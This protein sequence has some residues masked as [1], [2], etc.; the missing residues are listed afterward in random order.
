MRARFI[1]RARLISAALVLVVLC[2]L[3]RLW[4]VQVMDHEY[5]SALADRQYA[6][7]VTGLFERGSIYF[8]DRE[9]HSLAAATLRTGFALAIDPRLIK[10]PETVYAALSAIVPLEK[11]SFLE[12][13]AKKG[14]PHEDLLHRVSEEEAEAIRALSISGVVLY[15]EQWRF[16]PGGT[17]AANVIG[18]VGSDGESES[19]RYG[20]ERFY[21]DVLRRDDG[22]VSVNFFAEL[23]AGLGSL[24]SG[25]PFEGDIELTIEPTV[26]LTLEEALQEIQSVWSSKET[27]GI[28][29]DPRTGEI[30]AMGT[31]PTFDPNEFSSEKDTRVFS[32]PLV[33]NVYELGSIMKPIT[34][35]AGLDAG[36]VTPSSTYYDAGYIE[37]DGK[38]ISNFDG[39]GRGMVAMQEVL[40]QSLNT[41]AAYVESKIG[42][43]RFVDYLAAFGI[44]EESGID[45][46]NEASP[47]VQNLESPRNVEYATASF[48]QGIAL[49]PIAMTRALAALANGG[50]P[51]TPHV[52]RAI[53][54]RSGIT[55]EVSYPQRDAAITPEAA[56]EITRMLVAV[57]D[58]ALANG[59]QRFPEYSVAAKTGTA[60]IANPNGG[61]YYDDRY[62][63]SFFGYFP[64]YDPRYIIFLYTLEPKGVK[65]ASQTLSEP[66]RSLVSFLINYY[67]IPPDRSAI[68]KTP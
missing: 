59:A 18:F 22:G 40:N 47:L 68:T 5:Y 7:P 42:N 17:L 8:S 57:V 61:G 9:R 32:N 39:R 14:D 36:V 25:D 37:L 24:I 34:M 43:R 6:R 60:Q 65:Y 67:A 29:M 21:N 66:F 33:E 50:V 12:K 28:I 30:V 20:V 19:G 45:L 51:P 62:L 1:A 11:D 44:T 56:E 16:Y 23:F 13:A 52:V 15:R 26:Q 63:H 49:S 3:V 2:V 46:P 4:Q 41:G 27:G 53:H 38:R 35:A 64:A 48:G 55:K 54:Y 31:L 58:T 10:N